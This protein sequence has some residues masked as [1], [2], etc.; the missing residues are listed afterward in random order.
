[1][2]RSNTWGHDVA[3]RLGIRGSVERL[4]TRQGATLHI[5]CR[6]GNHIVDVKIRPNLDPNGTAKQMLNAGWTLG[7]NKLVCPECND[8]AK[9]AKQR[10]RA[11]EAAPLPMVEVPEAVSA[12]PLKGR[13]LGQR[14]MMEVTRERR[15]EIVRK[16]NRTKAERRAASAAPNIKEDA[17][18][19]DQE[20]AAPAAAS[21]E[22]RAAKRAVMQ[23]LD[24]AFNVEKGTYRAGIS[25]ASI[26]KETG[27]AEAKVK[28]LREEFYGPL[29][30]PEEL[31][32]MRDDLALVKKNIVAALAG[33][34]ETIARIER[35]FEAACAKNGWA[36]P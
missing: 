18:V 20:Q 3:H 4:D 15:S 6:R 16:G 34:D 13:R 21:D 27:V 17:P 26:A 29:G 25:D 33:Y 24:E 28:A 14:K 32:V 30:E 1:M 36:K 10:R 31:R 22:A 7:R 8:K 5:P 9:T 2:Q 12:P 11:A 23:W 19:A 35:R